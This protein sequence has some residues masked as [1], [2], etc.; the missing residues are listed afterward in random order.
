MSTKAPFSRVLDD[1]TQAGAESQ[2][3]RAA[4]L[5]TGW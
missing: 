2:Q 5:T 4:R 1:F 3:C